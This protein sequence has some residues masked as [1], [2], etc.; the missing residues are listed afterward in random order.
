VTKHHL[1]REVKQNMRLRDLY[2]DGQGSL[3]DWMVKE[4]VGSEDVKKV[5][6]AGTCV[7]KAPRNATGAFTADAAHEAMCGAL[8]SK[9]ECNSTSELWDPNDEDKGRKCKWEENDALYD[10]AVKAAKY[11]RI[12]INE[13]CPA[14]TKE[15]AAIGTLCCYTTYFFSKTKVP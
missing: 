6:K 13:K 2:D 3:S 7:A 5:L 9:G 10:Q 8:T 12:E 15:G 4:P 14:E 11:T 1:R